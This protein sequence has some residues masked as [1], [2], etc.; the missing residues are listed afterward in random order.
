MGVGVYALFTVL[1]SRSCK[2]SKQSIFPI[3]SSQ[4]LLF[5]VFTGKIFFPATAEQLKENDRK[6]EKIAFSCQW[7][8][9]WP[10]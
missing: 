5:P 10:G 6:I 9:T 3:A 4:S 7:N 1:G 8:Y 2:M